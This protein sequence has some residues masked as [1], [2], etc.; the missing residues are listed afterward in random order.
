VP[1]SQFK[2][3]EGVAYDQYDESKTAA[4]NRRV[5]VFMYASEKMIQEAQA[6]AARQ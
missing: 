5:E 1:N 6:E 4:E 2:S 3:V